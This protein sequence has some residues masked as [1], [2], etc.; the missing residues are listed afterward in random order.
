M[1]PPGFLQETNDAESGL[2]NIAK[3]TN[4][5]LATHFKMET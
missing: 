4:D 5:A 3:T 2:K 1:T